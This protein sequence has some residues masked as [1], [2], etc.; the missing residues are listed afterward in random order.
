MSDDSGAPAPPAADRFEGLGSFYLGTLQPG[1]TDSSGGAGGTEEGGRYAD[2]GG[3]FLY[4]AKDLTTHAVALG[5]TGSGKTGLCI[6]LLEEAALDGI[7]AIAVDLK[8]DIA[9]LLLTFPKLRPEDFR[10]WIDEAEAAR[11]GRT[12]DEH[13]AAVAAMWREG[14]ASTGQDGERIRRLRDAV[15]MAVYTPGGN[16]GRPLA[17]LRSFAAPSE[18]ILADSDALGDKVMS[19][20][21]GLLAL[22]GETGD[23]L[24]SR[25]HILLSRILHQAWT[26]GEDLDLAAL[27]HAVQDPGFDRIGVMDMESFFS[28]DDR[29]EFAA[30]L[31]NLIAAPGFEAWLQGEPLDIGSLLWTDAGKPRISIVSVAHLDEAE[32]QFFLTMLLN[33]IVAWVRS[34]PGT[35][36]LRAL[37]YID[38]VFGYLPPTAMPPTKP[39]L[40]TLL[41]QARAFGFGVVLATQNPVDLDYKALSNAGTWF[42][43]RLQTERDKLRVLDGLEGTEAMSGPGGLSRA[44][45]DDL[46]S[47]LDSRVFLVNN[48]HEDAPVV[49]RTRWAM[50]YLRGPL[51]RPEIKRLMAERGGASVSD[52]SGTGA[53]PAPRK[54]TK[55]A[56]ARPAGAHPAAS[57][58]HS[59][60][61]PSPAE[62]ARPMVP[63]KID[64]VFIDS[65]TGPYRPAL[66]GHAELHYAKA[67]LDLDHWTE[68]HCLA[69]LASDIPADPWEGARL[70][71]GA[72]DTEEEPEAG[73]GFASLPPGATDPAMYRSIAA[74]L[75][76]WLYRER[77]LTLRTCQVLKLTS[78]PDETEGEFVLRV[79]EAAREA[80]DETVEKLRDKYAAKV[81]RLE[82]RIDTAEDRV[83]RE[84]AEYE[85]H[86]NQSFVTMGTSILGA[87]LGRKTISKTNIGKVSTAARGFGRASKHKDDVGRAE[88]KVATLETDL[89]ALEA[90]MEEELATVRDAWAPDALEVE[91]VEIPPRKADIDV[92]RVALAWVRE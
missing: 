68:V 10:P 5:M 40:L 34:Q 67:G 41:K 86:R 12:P 18:T 25:K 37:L 30:Q 16:H 87:M 15:D 11:K 91:E 53:E 74:K 82:D 57:A 89:Q 69:G 28:A 35:S 64:E 83:R 1:A 23:P 49:I 38:E 8:G 24:N 36:S 71:E 78:R 76:S 59:G 3:P 90:E 20:V 60:A 81:K 77:R 19:A 62:A 54:A 84:E 85:Q 4:D 44:E 63:P 9:N 65:G 72:P 80:R 58:G 88:E 14:L 50:S 47:D 55:P 21:S 45:L 29:F 61:G 2:A 39:P 56:G 27:I 13:A 66:L 51:A 73:T 22:I 7:P 33:E 17:V 43:G 52:S 42:L 32:R 26:A 92:K 48:V 6:T 31:N 70:L 75:K 46:L 79:R